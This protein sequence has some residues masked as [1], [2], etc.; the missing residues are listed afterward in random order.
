M[1]YNL[2]Q[3]EL[4]LTISEL[5]DCYEYQK[6]NYLEN[7]LYNIENPGDNQWIV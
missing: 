1:D 3:L 4:D 6:N 7:L 2:S 5:D